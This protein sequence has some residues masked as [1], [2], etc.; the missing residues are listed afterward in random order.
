MRKLVII[1]FSVF[2]CTQLSG[3]F[4]D[5]ISLRRNS[6]IKYSEDFN[7]DPNGYLRHDGKYSA[8]SFFYTFPP[9]KSHNGIW[10]LYFFR[11][12]SFYIDFECDTTDMNPEVVEPYGIYNVI[13]SDLVQVNV[14]GYSSF[15][16]PLVMH[17]VY[18]RILNDS[19]VEPAEWINWDGNNYLKR[20][21]D[22]YRYVKVDSMPRFDIPIERYKWMWRKKKGTR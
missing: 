11:N 12:G 15:L 13:D 6:D 4:F 10:S 22:V 21:Q 19:T 3:C 9:N 1:I 18:F 16:Y 5:K 8:E 7:P 2:L 17:T 20:D 14:Y